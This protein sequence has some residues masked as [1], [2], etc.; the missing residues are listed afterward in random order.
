MSDYVQLTNL[1]MFDID[2]FAHKILTFN[3]GKHLEIHLTLY[4]DTLISSRGYSA[5]DRL[6]LPKTC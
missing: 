1:S 3:N 6:K 4:E 5:I 2:D